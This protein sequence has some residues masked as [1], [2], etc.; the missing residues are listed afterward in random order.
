[1]HAD[2]FVRKWGSTT[3]TESQ[4][5]H[6][7]F[8]D[9]C[10][11]LDEPTPA[12]ADPT[13]ATYCFE[14]R[15]AQAG[16]RPGWADVW[17]KDRF[18]WEYK[19]P[20]EDLDKAF[21]QLQ[22]YAPALGNPP[23]LIV[24]DLRSFRVHT[25][26]TY[27]VSQVYEIGP[28]DLLDPDKRLILKWAFSDPDRLKPT[29]TRQALTEEAAARFAALAARLE[30]RGYPSGEVAHFL[31]RLVFCMFAESVGLLRERMFSR[32]LDNTVHRPDRFAAKAAELFEAM[33]TGGEVGFEEV[34]WFNG[35]LF[36]DATALPLEPEDIVA[37]QK[38]AA[39]DWSDIDPSI[40]GTLFERG[41]TPER[42]GELARAIERR[43]AHGQS[44][45][46]VGVYYTPAA[47]IERLIEPVVVRPLRRD[48]ETARKTILAHLDQTRTGSPA[49]RQKA[50]RRAEKAFHDYLE[51]LR[52]FR[53]LDPA[54]GSGNF[55]YLAL[56]ALKD[57]E[58][59]VLVEGEALGFGRAFTLIGPEAV[60]G[61]EVNPLA[62]EL[63]RVSVWIGEIQWRHRHGLAPPRD[64]VLKP[65]KT[66]EHGN[67]LVSEDSGET[68]WPP[69]DA[70][71]GNPPFLGNKAMLRVLGEAETMR[72]RSVYAG[73][74][75]DAADLVCYWFEKARAMIAGGT[76]KRAGLVATNSIRGGANRA[77]L[78][79]IR[80]TGRIFEAWS[81]EPWD[82]DGAAVRVS[83]VCFGPKDTDG[84]PRLDGREVTEIF[85]DL[86]GG[87]VDL[88]MAKRLTENRGVSF[89]G[90]TKKGKFEAD[91]ATARAWLAEPLNPNGR[92]NSD[93][94]KPWINGL[95]VTRRPRDLW[96]VDFG[97]NMPEREAALFPGPFQHV[98]TNVRPVRATVRN[99]M[100][101]R[102]W[103]LHARAIHEL[104][105]SLARCPRYI[106]TPRVAK[107]RLFVWVAGTVLPDCQ[108]VS[109]TRDD[110]TIFGVLHSR[111]HELWA[112]RLGTSLED[113]PRYTP[114]TTFETF[115]FPAGLTPDR[116]A[117]DYADDPRAQAIAEAA[118]RLNRLRE[119]W[120][121]PPDLV[122]RVAEVMPD[123]PARMVPRDAG[124]AALLKK[125][126]LTNLYNDPPD[127]LRDAQRDLDAAVA[128]AYG[129][130][131]DLDD[132]EVL[133]RLLALNLRR[134]AGQDEPRQLRFHF[135]PHQLHFSLEGGAGRAPERRLRPRSRPPGP[136]RRQR[137][138]AYVIPG[139][140]TERLH[141]TIQ[142]RVAM[143][144]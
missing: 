97:P 37:V 100:E 119:A 91:Q 122:K 132:E 123:L 83:L 3:L 41:L 43:D 19:S 101:R 47:L 96:I 143:A 125:R 99:P 61:I 8:S 75:P 38:A 126:T 92:H 89:I 14:R 113:R 111:F 116:P 121:N 80:Q 31:I 67:A 30:R 13:G 63:A 26:W 78:D 114:S 110:D 10:R 23:L 50:R 1:M 135:P 86:T 64:P 120:L 70:I 98:V 139:G 115:P 57:L 18:A 118:K 2:S 16:G 124:A 46:A 5:A 42:R 15:V 82:L 136:D 49:A 103:W 106:A 21:T 28:A 60:R 44:Q 79:R 141:T 11:L 62:L 85:A 7:H 130:P 68:P 81:D 77:V 102:L 112:L 88:T 84:T 59:A 74:V 72:I 93:V 35:G 94:V 108:I 6:E 133:R 51:R 27:V 36:N 105:Q 24:S 140:L 137:H 138:F 12:Q 87:G 32:L 104:R 134:A 95:D 71:V 131:A 25:N 9:L 107:H 142:A 29:R 45:G 53:V 90:S 66:V 56:M 39:L 40:M 55:L 65:L 52:T 22:R 76:A 17:R 73:R 129:W 109:I 4:A 33:R 128:D 127:W 117:S 54:C 69:A 48:W 144:A 34:Q 58:H 20:G